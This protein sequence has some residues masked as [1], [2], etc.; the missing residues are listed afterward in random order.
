MTQEKTLLLEFAEGLTIFARYE[1]GDDYLTPSHDVIH[2][3][4]DPSVISAED[5]A[6]LE[7]LGWNRDDN[8]GCFYKFS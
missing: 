1:E 4:P 7:E 3:G 6:R 2:A 8:R 5:L